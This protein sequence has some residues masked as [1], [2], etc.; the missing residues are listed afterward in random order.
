MPDAASPASGHA[1]LCY[2]REDGEAVDHIEAMFAE[3]GVPVWRDVRDLWGGD[4]WKLH[5]RRAI[6]EGA[7]AFVAVFSK[8][9]QS[10]RK[11]FQREELL[12][13]IDEL[14]QRPPDR[15]WLIPVRLDECSIPD[16][17]IGPG[18]TLNDLQAVD[19]FPN[20]KRGMV[21]LVTSVLR[22]L[23]TDCPVPPVDTG[24]VVGELETL[25]PQPESRIKL[26]KLVLD[27]A[28]RT[29]T[30]LSDQ[31]TFP[32]DHPSVRS[33]VPGLRFLLQQAE[34][35]RKAVSGFVDVVSTLATW[36]SDPQYP[37][38][39]RALE[40]IAGRYRV[41]MS[42]KS[43]L[44]ELTRYPVLLCVWASG[45]AAVHRENYG[46]LKAA[47]VDAQFREKDTAQPM[48]GA[49]GRMEERLA[50]QA[51]LGGLAAEAQQ[52]SE[53]TDEQLTSL[54]SG[55]RLFSTPMSNH[56]YSYLR[57]RL[58]RLIPDDADYAEAFDRLEVFSGAMA[59][60]LR[61]NPPAS[62]VY[63]PLP[64][65]WRFLTYPNYLD[66][67]EARML[68]E[69]ASAGSAWPP[70]RGGLFGGSEQRAT[71]A[72]EAFVGYATEVR[73]TTPLG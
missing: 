50:D 19:L 47:L 8:N 41:A 13:A 61:A 49:I 51:F 62:G 11:T 56:L 39:R 66:P 17:D 60:D 34:A 35:Y 46:A 70:L 7:L 2:V 43:V 21:R 58:A 15:A 6:T 32:L 18:R 23:S 53:L 29:S 4:D 22:L 10:K 16:Y 40:R 38:L 44:L 65:Y 69:L 24:S 71:E 64:L 68:R 59:T 37:I 31:R 72:F 57:G 9:A 63:V 20:R 48:L 12:L 14:R 25:L 33:D 5:I 27:E 52:G 30:R 26:E 55:R 42:G 73:E 1:F 3:A 45:L 36:T 67:I 28:E 54:Q